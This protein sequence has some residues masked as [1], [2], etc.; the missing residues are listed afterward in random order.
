MI[1]LNEIYN[2][3]CLETMKK[4]GKCVDIVLTSPPYNMSKKRKGGISDSGRYDIYKDC[5]NIDEYI[6]FTINIFENFN[7]I[8]NENGIILYNFSYSIENPG[9]PYKLVSKILD[10][11]E[12]TLA[13]TVVWKKKSGLPFP[14]NP[15]RLSRIWEYVWIFVR[16]SEINTFN[17]NK[18]IASISEKTGQKYYNVYYNLFEAVNNDKATRNLNQATYSTDFCKYF[19]NIYGNEGYTVYDPFMGTGTTGKAC[20]ELK[21]NYIGSEISKEQCK[22]AKERIKNT[23]IE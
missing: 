2:E 3:D 13:D 20:K 4:M 21:M 11:T 10:E 23:F 8:V 22:Y 14:A 12:W 19:L 9:L 16:K 6:D 17:C 18:G 5:K 7:N 1:E 15:R